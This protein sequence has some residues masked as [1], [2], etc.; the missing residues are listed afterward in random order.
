MAT[1][2]AS[3]F[4]FEIAVCALASACAPDVHQ[5]DDAGEFVAFPSD[6]A[7][8]ESWTSYDLGGGDGGMI[9]DACAHTANVPR[10]AFMN[11]SPAHGST[12]FPVGTMIVKQIR[13]TSDPSTWQV[14]AMAKRGGG[15][16]AGSGCEGWEWYGLF[17]P[18]A[19]TG[20]EWS[21]TEPNAGSPYASC[22]AC[23]SCHSSA[24]NNDCVFAPELS[25]SQW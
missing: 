6:F 16:N 1:S 3:R 13:V 20:F 18:D 12:A 14:F 4:I 2:R 25:L 17:A 7:S 19:G 11:E 8:Y 9:G 5:A 10:V 15:F 23:T 22:G 21:G 24:Q